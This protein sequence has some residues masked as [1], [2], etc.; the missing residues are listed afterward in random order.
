MSE[1]TR[2]TGEIR[3]DPPIPWT[4]VADEQWLNIHRNYDR[5][6]VLRVV[7][8]PV[9]TPEGRLLRRQVDAIVPERQDQSAYHLTE[10]VQDLV[11]KYGAGRTFT[12]FL[13]CVWARGDDRWR[14]V[15]VDGEAKQIRPRIVWPDG[16]EEG[17]P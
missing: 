12:G 13:D 17:A 8:E 6:A 1:D 15:V 11:D 2:V 14:V 3:I 10:H 9:D 16:T 5:D 7:E 4:E